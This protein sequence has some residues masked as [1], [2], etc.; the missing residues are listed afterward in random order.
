[1]AHK[2]DTLPPRNGRYESGQSHAIGVEIP[3]YRRIR[4]TT[5]V[6]PLPTQPTRKDNKHNGVHPKAMHE[7]NDVLLR[8]SGCIAHYHATSL[9]T[10]IHYEDFWP[11]SGF[12]GSVEKEERP[13]LLGQELSST[14]HSPRRQIRR[15]WNRLATVF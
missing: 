12:S 14:G 1:M 9:L 2:M 13:G 4:K 11:E 15:P 5:Y 10:D 8:G 6:E 7:D 3:A